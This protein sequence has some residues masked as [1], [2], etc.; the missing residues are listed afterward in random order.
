MID[1]WDLALL[2]GATFCSYKW[3]RSV[4][5]ERWLERFQMGG[6]TLSLKQTTEE[7]Q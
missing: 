6:G 1:L 3:G 7:K 2:V 5:K 4:E